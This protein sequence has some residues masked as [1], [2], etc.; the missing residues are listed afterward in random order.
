MFVGSERSL[1]CQGGTSRYIY[2]EY[3]IVYKMIKASTHVKVVLICVT[4]FEIT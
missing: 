4:K 1:D 2:P 3:G